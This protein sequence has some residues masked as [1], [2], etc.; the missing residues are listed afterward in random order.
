MLMTDIEK[1]RRLFKKAGLAFPKIPDEL[2]TRLQERDKWVFSTREINISPYDIDYYVHEVNETQVED[3]TVLSHSGH[4]INSY[5]LQYYLVHGPLRMFLHL[6]WGGVYMD[7][8]ANAAKIRD[9]FSLADAIVLASK[10]VGRLAAGD[11]LMIVVSDFYGGYWSPPGENRREYETF[12]KD[13]AVVLTE[14]LHWL[15]NSQ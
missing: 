12:S 2:A 15:R 11:R 3:Y 8:K 6:G 14:V 9:C 4:G 5:A 7:V 1:A 10:T 13:P